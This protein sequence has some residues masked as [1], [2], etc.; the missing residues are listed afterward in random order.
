MEI[1][2]CSWVGKSPLLKP[3]I[4]KKQFTQ[5]NLKK[6]THKQKPQGFLFSFCQDDFIFC[7]TI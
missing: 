1:R 7:V 2:L 4:S 6:Q 3:Q 5:C